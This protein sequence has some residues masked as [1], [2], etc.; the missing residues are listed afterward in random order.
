MN[1]LFIRFD[2]AFVVLLE[3]HTTLPE[4]RHRTFNVIHWKIEDRER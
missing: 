3:A 4:L 1:A 2:I